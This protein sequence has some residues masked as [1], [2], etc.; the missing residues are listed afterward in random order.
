MT[1]ILLV[2]EICKKSF[3]LFGAFINKCNQKIW[4]L[5]LTLAVILLFVI[6]FK[7]F[8]INL[9]TLN[10]KYEIESY[11]MKKHKIEKILEEGMLKLMK[12]KSINI[13]IYLK[14]LYLIERIKPNYIYILYISINILN[15]A[16]ELK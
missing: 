1:N 10:M 4:L 3:D 12:D 11:R 8:N 14:Y 13:N 7:P 15:F 9:F 16:S 2:L 5:F 6:Q